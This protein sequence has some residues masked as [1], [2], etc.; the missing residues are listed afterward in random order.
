MEKNQL[1]VSKHQLKADN[2]ALF[3]SLNELSL[4]NISGGD[5]RH[6]EW[7]I[8]ESLAHSA[9]QQRIGLGHR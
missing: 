2:E 8:I 9:G 4:E 5:S 6:K 7:I 3:T 1:T